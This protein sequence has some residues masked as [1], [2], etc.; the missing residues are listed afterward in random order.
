MIDQIDSLCD[1]SSSGSR[2]KIF[3]NAPQALK[4]RINDLKVHFT[5]YDLFF[6]LKE[7]MQSGHF[8][9]NW[10]QNGCLSAL[11]SKPIGLTPISSKSSNLGGMEEGVLPTVCFEILHTLAHSSE[12]RDLCLL[13][14]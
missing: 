12:I 6:G 3:D 5:D 1:G 13:M 4:C 10:L 11:S 9:Q 2:M 7:Q 8:S 14:K